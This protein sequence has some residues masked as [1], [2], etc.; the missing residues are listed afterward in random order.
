MRGDAEDWWNRAVDERETAVML[1]SAGKWHQCYHHAG[2]AIEFA[3]KA[4]YLRRNGH[5]ILPESC[6]GA[7]WHSLEVIASEAKL[8]ADFGGLKADAKLYS[9]WLT[10]KDWDSNARFPGRPLPKAEVLD[11]MVAAFNPAKGLFGWLE[12]IFQKS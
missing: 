1:R 2:Q 10:V 6:R 12:S 7:R 5:K 3:L 8:S 11:F 4:I 9:N